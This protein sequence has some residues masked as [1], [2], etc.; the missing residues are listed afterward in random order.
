[1]MGRKD[2]TAELSE[3]VRK[4]LA[5]STPY[6]A[7]Q[8]D[9]EPTKYGSCGI[10]DFMAF[11]PA[12]SQLQGVPSRVAVEQGR[13][14]FYEVKSCMDDFNSGHGLN[15]HGDRNYLVCERELADE[16]HN[17]MMIPGTC[18]VLCPDRARGRLVA[19]YDTGWERGQRRCTSGELLF[20]LLMAIKNGRGA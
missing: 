3:L 1:M 8:V 4:R 16:L 6:W 7:E 14:D 10:V 13:F 11:Y 9:V 18:S 19:T 20:C 17:R 2:T 15:F 12:W 5:N